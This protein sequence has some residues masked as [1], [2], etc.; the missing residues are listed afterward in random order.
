MLPCLSPLMNW[1]PVEAEDSEKEVI[2]CSST[3]PALIDFK[4]NG[5]LKGLFFFTGYK[6]A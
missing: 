2:H 6:D 5:W 3:N 1:L 4:I